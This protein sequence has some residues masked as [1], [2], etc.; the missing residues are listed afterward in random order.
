[1]VGIFENYLPRLWLN[2]LPRLW[3]AAQVGTKMLGLPA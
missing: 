1:M 3:L 2:Y